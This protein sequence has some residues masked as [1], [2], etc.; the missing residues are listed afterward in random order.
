MR[1]LK[2]DAWSARF[3]QATRLLAALSA[4]ILLFMVGLIGFGVVMRYVVGQPILG[5]NEIVQLGA[6]A[7][8]MM[9]L[10]YTTHVR[11][12]VRADIFDRPLGPKGRLAGDLLTRALSIVTLWVLVGRAWDKT[13]DAFEFGDETNMLGLPIWPVYGFI[14][15]A[16]ALTLVVLALQFLSILFSGKAMDD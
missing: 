13:T 10:P 5:I 2:I 12:H 8:V 3:G 7:L 15:L 1:A 9:A 4:V 16:V 14:A 11:G 6:V